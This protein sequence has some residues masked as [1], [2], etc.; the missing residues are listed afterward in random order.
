MRDQFG[1]L[2]VFSDRVV[3]FRAKGAFRSRPTEVVLGAEGRIG[4]R[5]I[6]TTNRSWG[7]LELF[8]DN[9]SLWEF[10]IPRA[11]LGDARKVADTL[12]RIGAI[13]RAG[14]PRSCDGG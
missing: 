1:V 14:E 3:L 4:T 9:G 8:F 11:G 6:F 12:G 7:V 10:D 2:A 5:A 13:E